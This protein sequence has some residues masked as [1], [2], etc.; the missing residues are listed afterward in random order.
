MSSD[1]S[2][3]TRDANES[4]VVEYGAR[5]GYAIVG[6]LHLL[7]AWIAV[8]VAWG[9]GGGSKSADQSGALGTLSTSGTGKALLWVA[10]VGFALLAVWNLTEAAISHGETADRVKLAAKGVM[11]AFFAWTSFKVVALGGGGSSEKQTEDFTAT[12]MKSP[13]GQLLVGALGLVVLGIAGY[14]VYKGWK[15]T[16][17]ED[18]VGHPG[19][20]AVQAGRAGYV[21]KGVALAVVGVFFVVAAVKHD[22]DKAQGLDGALKSLKDM[23]FGPV[24]LTVVALGIAAYGVYSFARARYARL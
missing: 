23:A 22:A 4:P 20:W 14:H 7:I 12:L 9:I 1:V 10:V 24:L 19:D 5:V 3:A 16:F 6:V 2:R 17:L 18:L 13:A 11:Y 15:K 8:K 21:A